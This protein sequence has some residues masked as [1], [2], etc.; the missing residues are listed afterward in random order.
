MSKQKLVVIGLDGMEKALLEIL[1]QKNKTPHLQKFVSENNFHLLKSTIPPSSF[2]AWPVMLTSKNQGEIGCYDT[3]SKKDYSYGTKSFSN[4]KN[5]WDELSDNGKTVGV[6]NMPGTF[7]AKKVNGFMITGIYTPSQNDNFIYPPSLK[8]EIKE[9]LKDY[10]FFIKYNDEMDF[11]QRIISLIKT[12]FKIINKLYFKYQPDFFI[13]EES[14]TDWIQH[15]F[16]KYLYKSHPQYEESNYKEVVYGYFKLLDSLIGDFLAKLEPNTKIMIV[17]DHGSQPQKGK[18]FL[19]NLLEE[20]NFLKLKSDM[21]IPLKI[22]NWLKLNDEKIMYV[23]SKIKIKRIVSKILAGTNLN[24]KLVRAGGGINWNVAVEKDL[25]DWKKTKAFSMFDGF[26]YINKKNRER[27]G[28]VSDEEYEEIRNEIIKELRKIKEL[29]LIIYKKEELYFGK[30]FD[31][32]PD[33]VVHEESFQYWPTDSVKT[34]KFVIPL[35]KYAYH[36]GTHSPNGIFISNL[37]EIPDRNLDA[38]YVGKRICQFFGV[39]NNSRIK[40]I[41]ENIKI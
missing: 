6:L 28:I 40:E 18:F 35:D 15:C 2:P 34:N 8:E 12:R 11:I 23:L 38:S 16:S 41:I 37:S 9:E 4:L 19:N 13:F 22:M 25:I 14:T 26:I 33:L 24:R 7:P 3:L 5:I 17:S 30:D 10:D 31:N 32:A 27:E 1:I 20:K 21:P 36:N 29:K 39:K